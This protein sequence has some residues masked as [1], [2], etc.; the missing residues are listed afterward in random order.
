MFAQVS[1]KVRRAQ[2]LAIRRDRRR[3]GVEQLARRKSVDVRRPL[4][5][6]SQMR[7][8][9]EERFPA[10][11]IAKLVKEYRI[12]STRTA[13]VK[14]SLIIVYGCLACTMLITPAVNS[15][16]HMA[17]TPVERADEELGVASA[18]REI[19]LNSK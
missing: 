14:I 16:S 17:Y 9:R 7:G 15:I 3:N 19:Q 10:L 8:E 2:L 12:S 11:S 13:Y 18:T 1:K 5:W 6:G 4:T